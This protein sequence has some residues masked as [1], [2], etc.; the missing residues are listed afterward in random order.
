MT[1]N[2]RKWQSIF[3]GKWRDLN[4]GQQTPSGIETRQGFFTGS[5]DVLQ[6]LT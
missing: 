2:D 1:E 3:S 4:L 6:S 5:K